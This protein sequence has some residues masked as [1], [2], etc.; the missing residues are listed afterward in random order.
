MTHPGW[1]GGFPGD[2]TYQGDVKLLIKDTIQTIQISLRLLFVE[3][4]DIDVILIW[5]D[6]TDDD[7]LKAAR[8]MQ[9]IKYQVIIIGTGIFLVG[10]SMPPFN[11]NNGTT[12][13]NVL[14]LITYSGFPKENDIGDSSNY[15]V[16]LRAY[17]ND[18]FSSM[19]GIFNTEF[20]NTPIPRDK[21]IQGTINQ[22]SFYCALD[23]GYEVKCGKK[24]IAH[25][26]HNIFN[27]KNIDILSKYRTK[28]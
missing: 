12:K 1:I 10:Y 18:E 4:A 2:W 23:S 19:D 7:R 11:T 8:K 26:D 27:S 15:F 17:L 9:D 14:R 28:N 16:K 6:I 3:E 25:T 21:N 20:E 24:Y 22:P 13:F 5:K